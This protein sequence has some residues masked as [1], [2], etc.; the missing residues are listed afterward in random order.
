[1]TNKANEAIKVD[2]VIEAGKTSLAEANELLAT[3]SIAVV[4]K[5]SSKLLLDDFIVVIAHI[6]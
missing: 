6:C 4:I 3:N 2:E 1:L 5:Y